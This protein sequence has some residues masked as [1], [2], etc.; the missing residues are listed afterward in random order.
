LLLLVG[1]PGFIRLCFVLLLLFFFLGL[2]PIGLLFLGLFFFWLFLCWFLFILIGLLQGIGG[3]GYE[4]GEQGCTKCESHIFLS[5][6]FPVHYIHG[7]FSL[8][9]AARV[10]GAK[11]PRLEFGMTRI[12]ML[13]NSTRGEA[14][15]QFA[16]VEIRCSGPLEGRGGGVVRRTEGR[17]TEMAVD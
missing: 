16:L 4:Q 11:E 2:L 7:S 3:G 15:A 8:Y 1:L 9:L 5:S 14:R 10:Y 6:K 12:L 17:Q 13:T